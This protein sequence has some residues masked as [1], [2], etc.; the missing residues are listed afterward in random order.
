[1]SRLLDLPAELRMKI[2]ELVTEDGLCK[3]SG[4]VQLHKYPLYENRAY[5]TPWS[6]IAQTNKQMKDEVSAA[7]LRTKPRLRCVVPGHVYNCEI[8]K[9][10]G[11]WF[12]HHAVVVLKAASPKE[13]VKGH[14][15]CQIFEKVS[16]KVY[17]EIQY[18]RCTLDV[19]REIVYL[20]KSVDSKGIFA[21][22]LEDAS[23]KASGR[24]WTKADVIF[25]GLN[26]RDK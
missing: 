12:M 21:G 19:H 6:G 22:L 24:V 14:L 20:V 18:W 5:I 11:V 13:A 15:G 4:E 7:L 1:M 17:T 9:P 8:G 23:Y 16:G 3:V 25:R 10:M 26:A 2:L